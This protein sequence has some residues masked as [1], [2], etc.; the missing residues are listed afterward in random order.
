MKFT[1]SI[2]LVA[3]TGLFIAMT[4]A[5]ALPEPAKSCGTQGDLCVGPASEHPACCSGLSCV[6][7]GAGVHVSSL[8]SFV[9]M[10]EDVE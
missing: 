7:I 10:D 3:I 9:L 5:S 8:Y 6:N 2:L 1:T 4:H